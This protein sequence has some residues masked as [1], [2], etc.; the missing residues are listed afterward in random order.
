MEP[1]AADVKKKVPRI[2]SDSSMTRPAKSE[3]KAQ[4]NWSIVKKVN[5]VNIGIFSQVTPGARYQR[6]VTRMF[7]VPIVTDAT[8]V[9]IPA[10][11]SVSPA[12]GLNCREVR[13][14]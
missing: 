14:E 2:L 1:P 6:I 7:T 12:P 4:R 5:H 9:S 8:S 3:G 13:G 10:A 11:P